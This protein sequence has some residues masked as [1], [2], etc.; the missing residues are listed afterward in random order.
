MQRCGGESFR[1][2]SSSTGSTRSC[3]PAPRREAAAA[4]HQPAARGDDAARLQRA[5][6]H[7]GVGSL[8]TPR[9]FDG[10]RGAVSPEFGA[11]RLRRTSQREVDKTGVGDVLIDVRWAGPA[12]SGDGWDGTRE[13]AWKFR[14]SD[15]EPPRGYRSAGPR[16]TTRR[17]RAARSR[18]RFMLCWSVAKVSQASR[19]SRTASMA[20][21]LSADLFW[22]WPRGSASGL[23]DG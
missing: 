22:L 1:P 6:D 8:F 14:V 18:G 17:E 15:G 3:V 4:D 23:G 19:S 10:W 7:G 20:A 9:R 5:G 13:P 16:P 2:G 12:G 11:S 21:E